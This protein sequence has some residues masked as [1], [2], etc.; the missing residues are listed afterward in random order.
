MSK[1]NIQMGDEVQCIVTGFKGVVTSITEY[2]NGCRRMGVQPPVDKEGRIP[3]AYNIDEPQLVV[4][5]ARK[6]KMGPQDTGGPM[7]RIPSSK[8]SRC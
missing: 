4:T 6:V 1:S 5:K 7:L 8:I 3:E 2:L